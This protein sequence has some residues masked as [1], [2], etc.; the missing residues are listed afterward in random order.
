MK[1]KHSTVLLE[2]AGCVAGSIQTIEHALRQ[3]PGVVRVYVN[4][5]TEAAYVEYDPDSCTEAALVAAIQSIGVQAVATTPT[6]DRIL[7]TFHR[8]NLR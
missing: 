8:R 7:S 2:D 5:V 3:V 1:T 4:P 6:A